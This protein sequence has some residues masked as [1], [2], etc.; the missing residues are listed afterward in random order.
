MLFAWLFVA[1]CLGW[2]V[3]M[4]AD[5]YFS[6]N[7]QMRREIDSSNRR[8]RE[9]EK[10]VRLQSIQINDLRMKVDIL[11]QSTVYVGR[12]YPRS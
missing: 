1:I 11:S 5:E 2:G 6:E 4:K 7:Q 9:L 3:L 12:L 8:I 10:R